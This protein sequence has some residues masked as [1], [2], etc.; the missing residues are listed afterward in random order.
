MT[1]EL[2]LVTMWKLIIYFSALELVNGGGHTAVEEFGFITQPPESRSHVG[3]DK[4]F[5]L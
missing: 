3:I 2:L 5:D 1:L 4:N